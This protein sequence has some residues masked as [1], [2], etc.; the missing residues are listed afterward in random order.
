MRTVF[1]DQLSNMKLG[2]NCDDRKAEV[3]Q[4]MEK[5]DKNDYLTDEE[6]DEANDFE[7]QVPDLDELIGQFE[8][9]DE[10]VQKHYENIKEYEDK[11]I[12]KGFKP[13]KRHELK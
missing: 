4:I 7:L 9:E 2:F 5:P 10:V 3:P 13:A 1:I 11:E 8:K 6:S 12:A